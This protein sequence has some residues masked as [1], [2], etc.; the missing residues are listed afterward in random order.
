M[1]GGGGGYP[2]LGEDALLLEGAGDER[3]ELHHLP[4]VV[5]HGGP[6]LPA[7]L[8]TGE[9]AEQSLWAWI[10]ASSPLQAPQRSGRKR[11]SRDPQHERH[12]QVGL[13]NV[14]E[15]LFSIYFGI[16]LSQEWD[17]LTFWPGEDIDDFALRLSGLVQQLARHGDDN[18]DE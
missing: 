1:R 6:G 14:P 4:R 11:G 10:V 15:F 13:R 16:W 2:D 9:A 17:R 3:L 5:V 18:I 8:V 7:A 12:R